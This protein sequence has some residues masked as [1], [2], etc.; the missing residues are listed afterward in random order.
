LTGC[1]FTLPV[2]RLYNILANTLFRFLLARLCILSLADKTTPKAIRLALQ[3]FQ[4]TNSVSDEDSRMQVLSDAYEKIMERISGQKLGY[5]RLAMQVLSWISCSKRRLRVI[6]LQHA[7]AVQIDDCELDYDNIPEVEDI[8]SACAG[9]VTVDKQTTIIRLVHYTTQEFLERTQAQWFPD[10][11]LDITKACITY[12]SFTTF[13]SGPSQSDKEY[14]DRLHANPLYS[15]AANYWGLHARQTSEYLDGITR[16]LQDTPKVRASA[17]VLLSGKSLWKPGY[18]Q[19]TPREVTDIHLAAY[20]G[21]HDIISRLLQQGR[22]IDSQDSD[23]RTPLSYA[24]QNGNEEAVRLLL[25]Q[26]ATVDKADGQARS[27][28]SWAAARGHETVVELLLNAGADTEKVS[29]SGWTPLSWAAA[30]GYGSVVRLLLHQD[31]DTEGKD[32][33]GRTPLSWAA[34]DGNDDMIHQLL[35]NGAAVNTKDNLGRTPLTWAVMA[36]HSNVVR[37]LLENGADV[38]SEEID[39]WTPTLWAS[40]YGNHAIVK[41][42]VDNNANLDCKDSNGRSPLSWA[43]ANGHYEVVK[44]LLSSGRSHPILEDVDGWTALSWATSNGHEDI[45]KLLLGVQYALNPLHWTSESHEQTSLLGPRGLGNH[46]VLSHPT[47]RDRK[48]I[49]HILQ[50]IGSKREVA[51]YVRLFTSLSPQKFAVMK[52]EHGVLVNHMD[53]LISGLRTLYHLGLYPIIIHEVGLGA[54]TAADEAKTDISVEEGL[55]LTR[56]KMISDKAREIF[57]H[58]NSKLARELCEAGISTQPFPSGIFTASNQDQEEH[59]SEDI[60]T[61]VNTRPIEIAINR[62]FIP[63]ILPIG[64][65]AQGGSCL[66]GIDGATSLLA[67]AITPVKVLYISAEGGLRD[68]SDYMISR[69]NLDTEYQRFMSESWIGHRTRQ[70]MRE[71]KELLDHLPRSSSVAIVHPND[72]QKE[73]F[74][75][76]G[77]GTLIRRSKTVLVADSIAQFPDIQQLRTALTRDCATQDAKVIADQCIKYL[78]ENKFRAYY[79]RAMTC[80]AFVL[81]P[82]TGSWKMP[83]TLACM[84]TTMEG[85]LTDVATNVFNAIK[86]DYPRLVWAVRSEDENLSWFTSVAEGS[87]PNRVSGYCMFWYGMAAEDLRAL[88]DDFTSLGDGI[89]PRFNFKSLTEGEFGWRNFSSIVEGCNVEVS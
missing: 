67:R 2:L 80:I 74:T 57:E 45:I 58:E 82:I 46:R 21:I 20:F 44:L 42:L 79:D 59:K 85:W 10:V 39:G 40:R 7:L 29:E 23:G 66:L 49:I 60:I 11:Q 32:S 9:L 52:I 84:S 62:G 78:N 76:S 18:S 48:L 43:S 3:A 72:L 36:G 54:D 87:L 31:A 13:D 41:L 33:S 71:V 22:D 56:S 63:M 61:Q 6:E 55:R 77:A 34:E 26:G 47:H 8:V 37:C 65:T 38:N 16:F 27:P 15:Y 28:L 30:S 5:K 88:V 89:L 35:E 50:S 75:H 83:A 51:Q 68:S 86:K 17:Q 1:K 14:E 4:M 81:P 19:T 25:D 70:K 64:S 24:A 53:G 73:L 12:L 69:I